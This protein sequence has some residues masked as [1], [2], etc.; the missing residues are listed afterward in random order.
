MYLELFHGRNFPDEHLDDWGFEGPIIG[1]FDNAHGTYTT[2]MK[3]WSERLQATYEVPFHD[4]MI[5][6]DGKYFGDWVLLPTCPKELRHRR[7]SLKRSKL[8]VF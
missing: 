8:E 3:L 5:E 2:H 6:Y 1:P 4:D 7:V